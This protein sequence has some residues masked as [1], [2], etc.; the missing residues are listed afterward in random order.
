MGHIPQRESRSL[1][2]LTAQCRWPQKAMTLRI[3]HCSLTVGLRLTEHF[4]LSKGYFPLTAALEPI[5]K[6]PFREAHVGESP[7]H[8]DRV[9][10][11]EADPN[12]TVGVVTRYA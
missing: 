10:H 8:Q 3:T 5:V 11:R 7:G 6:P 12:L 9:Q 4:P 1:G 2:G